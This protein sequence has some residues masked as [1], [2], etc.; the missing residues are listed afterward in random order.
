MG[1]GWLPK[2]RGLYLFSFRRL[3]F[4]LKFNIEAWP[5]KKIPGG[6]SWVT[7][8]TIGGNMSHMDGLTIF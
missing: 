1:R 8:Y 3:S 2:I 6:N 7:G 5:L 4:Q